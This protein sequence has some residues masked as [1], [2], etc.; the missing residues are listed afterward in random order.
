MTAPE[1]TVTPTHRNAVAS[2]P[3]P[4]A[5][6]RFTRFCGDSL[7]PWL[8]KFMLWAWGIFNIGLLV[9][10]I[11]TSF[12]ST[13]EILLGPF[14]LPS[15]IE[16]DNY[17]TAWTVAGFGQATLA[18]LVFVGATLIIVLAVSTPAAYALA[19]MT[20]RGADRLTYYFALG[21]ALPMQSVL[22]PFF[23]MNTSFGMFMVDW[24]TGIWDPRIGLIILY[25]ATAI[26]WTVFIL[27]AF[28]KSLPASLEEAAALDGAGPWTTFRRIMI[29][30]AK[31]P[32]T[33]VAMITA[34]GAWNETLL[35]LVLVPD[36]ALRTLPA[37]LLNMYY[38]LQYTSNWGALFAGVV[39]VIGPIVL[40]YA[41]AGRRIVEGA[42]MGA[43]K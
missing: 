10:V 27:T 18:T 7:V 9:W 42:T 41:W 5:W 40:L 19:R 23:L 3:T 16:W 21:I 1:K 43:V 36:G 2:Q 30:L 22:I 20:G 35:V 11:M 25:S 17:V 28:F 34:I 4:S 38:S 26:P 32:L 8:C 31:G 37:A 39:L 33:T 29:P 14:A 24:V 6:R 13:S 12:K 15:K